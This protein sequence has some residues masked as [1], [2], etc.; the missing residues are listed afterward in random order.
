MT[1]DAQLDESIADCR[2][3]AARLATSAPAEAARLLARLRRDTFAAAEDW[4]AG[5]CESKGIDPATP[6]AAEEWLAGP[7]ACLRHLRSLQ[8]T[9]EH[10]QHTGAGRIASSE[11]SSRS[12]RTVA[13]VFPETLTDRLVLSD[14][15]AEVWME[16]G[17]SPEQVLRTTGQV[18]TGAAPAPRVAAILGAGNVSSIG[19][20]DVIHKIFAERQT[21]VLKLH[22]VNAYLAPAYARAFAALIDADY[23]RLM[24]GDAELGAALVQHDGIDSVHMT[25]SAEVHDRIVWGGA[26]EGAANRAANM[27]R[28]QK[29]ITSELGCVTPVVIVPGTWTR[30]ELLFQARNIAT[31]VANNASFNCNAAKVLVTSADWTQR[32]EFLAAVRAALASIPSRLAYYPGSFERYE[33]YEAATPGAERLGSAPPGHLPW[34]FA[35]G[36]D[37]GD[38]DSRAFRSEAWCGVLCETALPATGPSN[39]LARA[40]R[41]C[42]ETLFGTLSMSLVIDPTTRRHHAT[43]F[44]AALQELTYGSI[45]VNHWGAVSY[46]LVVTPWGAHPGHTI[47][48]IQ[49]GRGFVHNTRLFERVQKAVVEGP[50]APRITPLWFV[51]HRHA[52][53]ASRALCAFESSPGPLSLFRLALHGLRG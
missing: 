29:P 25:G 37:A 44:E 36:L 8:T 47:D 27:P 15:R 7:V 38:S 31:Q 9:L 2:R 42:N 16:P 18:W 30:R 40:T 50:F 24:E 51:G 46:A 34:L 6:L 4:C 48:D 23:L 33:A 11:L 17:I 35:T 39:F 12:G 1:P 28:L 22:P 43:A 5:A 19:A 21:C 3:G 52:L 20:M 10:M 41:F 45:V 53:P 26:A 32:A 14:F 49:S 13:R